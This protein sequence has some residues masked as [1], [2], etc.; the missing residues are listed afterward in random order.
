M[1]D[2][3][4]PDSNQTRW[5][6]AWIALIAVA[7]LLRFF[8]LGVRSMSHDESMHAYYSWLF[9]QNGDYRHD[10]ALHGP[11]LFHFNA[12]VYF[13]MGAGDAT[14]RLGPALAGCGLVAL[15]RS[16]GR[17]IG[18]RGAFLAGV[19][20]TISPALLYYSRYLR[21]DAYIALF[22]LAWIYGAFRYLEKREG[23]WLFVTVAAMALS[24]VTKE[25]SFLFGAIA[26]SYFAFRAWRMRRQDGLFRSAE[27]ELA[28]L[29]LTLVLPFTAAFAYPL[30]GWEIGSFREPERHLSN[31]GLTLLLAALSG[32]LAWV[33]LGRSTNGIDRRLWA[34]MMALFW[35]VQLLLFTTFLTQLQGGWVSGVVGSM[36]Y[37][38]T[39]HPVSRGDQPWFYYAMLMALY[40]FLPLC[41]SLA[42][43]ARLGRHREADS[44]ERSSF[45][46]FL[47]WWTVGSW[48]AYSIAGE[49]M[50]WL[51]VHIALP[52]LLLSGWWLASFV[53][54]IDWRRAARDRTVWLA[55]TVPLILIA[56]IRLPGVAGGPTPSRLVNLLP[57]L[58]FVAIPT[59]LSWRFLRTAGWRTG[60]RIGLAGCVGL[61]GLLTLRASLKLNFVNHDLATEPLVYAHGTPDIKRVMSEIEEIGLRT[62]GERQLRLAYDDD[63][64]WP[65][66]WYL[67][68]YKNAV[69]LGD[70]L[71]AES[72]SAPVVLVGPKN[73]QAFSA[74]LSA[75]HRQY[76]YRM[77]WWPLENYRDLDRR[78][79]ARLVTDPSERN[80]LRRLFLH[81]DHGDARP[82]AWPQLKT[83]NLYV[84][85]DLEPQS[86]PPTPPELPPPPEAEIVVI[87]THDGSYDGSPLLSPRDVAVGSKGIRLI[88]DTGNH[89]IVVLDRQG[90]LIRT[91]GSHC[92]L[93][94][95]TDG[96][97][98]RD[99]DG[100][101]PLAEGDGQFDEPWGV[102][103]DSRGNVYVADTWNGRIQVFDQY[104]RFVRKWGR[105]GS[106]RGV[107]GNPDV[108][109]GPR[110]LIVDSRGNV[111]LSDTGNKRILRFSPE[112]AL[113]DQIGGH[114]AA[115]GLFDEPVGVTLNLFDRGLLIVDTWNQRVQKLDSRLGFETEWIL[116]RPA[117]ARAPGKPYIVSA[118]DGRVFVSDPDRARILVFGS[119]GALRLALAGTSPESELDSPG[120][121]AFDV[122]ADA[123]LV[124][125]A[126]N[127]RILLVAAAT[128]DESA[129]G[130]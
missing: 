110:D 97:E 22:T 30:L 101:G 127:D 109:Y 118:P 91:F 114:G 69:G 15:A 19:L 2:T 28:L 95:E 24:F 16:L 125:D 50:P 39:Q 83:L 124:A 76:D 47:V 71:T 25:T 130:E 87:D 117:R 1:N 94:R 40:E 18:R 26:G 9:L 108:L 103:V 14:A 121:L 66:A 89:R 53:E 88:A 59:F 5:T 104:G 45:V 20:L 13:L 85:R 17:Y 7:A 93:V 42:A 92:P 72:L 38:L 32:L 60:L 65:F 102:A 43:M 46:G 29:M 33:G 4:A 52:S 78:N 35:C 82:G 48:L 62:T 57:E 70:T 86:W 61:L 77:M 113:I 100:P 75:S 58:L 6:I 8:L 34:K 123:L 96:G 126:G 122:Q 74:R 41:L 98:C 111:V 73:A 44:G 3:N 105:P 129:A 128:D 37:W 21:N 64:S 31:I 116:P 81:R 23:R 12:L 112:G 84:R 67:R 79:L 99:P 10:P 49:K 51:L 120:G 63:S 119:D 27:A 115:P 107:A 55:A 106:T 11:F 80:R 36:G 90:G 54:R 56:L 68:D